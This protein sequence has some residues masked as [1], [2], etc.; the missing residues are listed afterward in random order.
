MGQAS[1]TATAAL[2]DHPIVSI[3]PRAGWS[4]S[5]VSELWAYRELLGFLAWRDLKVRYK[6]TVL[7]AAWAIAQPLFTAVT[8][9]IFFGRFAA[10]PSDGI[11]YPVFAFAGT[12][13]WTL[14]A[15]ATLNAGASLIGSP[16]LVMKVYLPRV[17]IPLAAAIPP[18][19]DFLVGAA[20]L[21]TMMAYYRV[22]PSAAVMIVP[23][24]AVLVTVLAAGVGMIAAASIAR[25]RDLRHVLP[26]V[27]QLWMFA[28][29]VIYPASL[30]PE[31]W[32]WLL[33]LNPMSG[34]IEAFRAAL[35]GRPIGM[36]SLVMAVAV[37]LSVAAVG[38]VVFRRMERMFADVM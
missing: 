5:D 23:V 32:R 9:T 4:G 33:N 1:P 27:V 38:L 17:I 36:A 30:M 16:H 12:L 25:F 28:S 11:P 20:L 18:V 35:F 24:L 29:P 7:G 6:Q 14:F 22:S 13:V 10:I 31:R 21:V 34:L 15:N 3:R 26:F 19:A 8:L 2:P 37:T